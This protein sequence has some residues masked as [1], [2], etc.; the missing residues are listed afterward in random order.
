MILSRSNHRSVRLILS[1][2]HSS[3]IKGPQCCGCLRLS[4]SSTRLFSFPSAPE[5]PYPLSRFCLS[6][7][8]S[9]SPHRNPATPPTNSSSSGICQLQSLEQ[10]IFKRHIFYE[11]ATRIS[12]RPL[13]RASGFASEIP[14]PP[15][16]T[17]H[18]VHDSSPS[19]WPTPAPSSSSR[20]CT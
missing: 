6:V 5:Q 8:I 16:C 10:S 17:T 19:P 11:P 2:S 20:N 4:L 13:K 14:L 15:D 1:F 9:G 12:P 7:N 18:K 3:H